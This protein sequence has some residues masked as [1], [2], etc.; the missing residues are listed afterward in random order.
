MLYICGTKH[1]DMTKYVILTRVSTKKQVD[2]SGNGL[3]LD[4]QLSNCR[5][6]VSSVGGKILREFREVQSAHHKDIISLDKSFDLGTLLSKRPV[7]LDTIKY[8]RIHGATILVNDISRLTRFKLL[9]EYLMAT[10][11]KFQ[12]ADSPGDDNFIIGIKIALAED[13][14]RKV[15]YNTR[16]A[17]Q[18]KIATTGMWHIPYNKQIKDGSYLVQARKVL[19]DNA[20]NN[21]NTIRAID[22]ICDKKEKGWTLDTI[23]IH[24]NDK[25]Y[26]TPRGK[27]W[28]KSQVHR[29]VSKHCSV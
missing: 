6:F 13:Y 21:P 24:L 1:K 28:S 27:T 3:G 17:L 5:T 7:L 12:C 9:G 15:A 29:I 14:A 26:L 4:S 8:A 25:G 16:K 18:H 22:V 23:A 20:R 11:V 10:G 19:S 2:D